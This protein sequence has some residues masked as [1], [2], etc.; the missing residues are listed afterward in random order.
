MFDVAR[1][2]KEV[3]A[4]IILLAVGVGRATFAVAAPLLCVRDISVVCSL[5]VFPYA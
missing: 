5:K 4:L 2:L 1:S 3:V